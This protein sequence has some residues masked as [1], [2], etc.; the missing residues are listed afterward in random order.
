MSIDKEKVYN[1]LLNIKRFLYHDLILLR[2][3]KDY[4][5]NNHLISSINIS[6][7]VKTDMYGYIEK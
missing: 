6:V 2:R 7:C 1:T 4:K 3:I 5:N